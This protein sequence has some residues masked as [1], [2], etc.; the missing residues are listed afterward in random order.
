[1][2]KTVPFEVFGA[3]Q[4]IYFD[5]NRLMRLEQLLGKSITHIVAV[6]DITI[7]FLVK[8]LM[9]GLSHHSRDNAAQW[10][11]KLKKFFGGG[12]SIEELAE[13]ILLAIIGSGIFGKIETDD[14]EEGEE[15]N[16]PATAELSD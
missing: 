2:K 16:A 5:I 7:D 14:E 10:T 11:N 9:V 13:P 15:K 1:M 4:F 12:G 8:S 6:H 3:N